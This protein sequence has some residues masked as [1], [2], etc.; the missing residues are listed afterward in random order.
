MTSSVSEPLMARCAYR[1]LSTR[2]SFWLMS[3]A[4]SS[5]WFT[6]PELIAMNCAPPRSKYS[7]MSSSTLLMAPTVVTANVPWCERT[8]SGC[9]SVS[10]M[11]PMP[12]VPWKRSRSLS[13]RE[14]N[15]VFSME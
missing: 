3:A 6:A 8:S 1:M 13:N 7:S 11:H 15:G 10:E 2:S 14:R 12:L 5:V 4:T 9:G